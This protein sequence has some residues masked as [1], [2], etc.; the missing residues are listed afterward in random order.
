MKK[1]LQ[2]SLLTFV[3]GSIAYSLW[4]RI[5]EAREPGHTASPVWSTAKAKDPADATTVVVTYFTTDARCD[6]CLT[7]EKRARAIVDEQFAEEVKAGRVRFQTLNLDRPE[8]KHF[9]RDYNM[10][11]KTVVVSL[12]A[13]GEVLRWEKRDDVWKLLNAPEQFNS[14]VAA[15]IRDL[16]DTS[17]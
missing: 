6:S 11:F 9:A 7:I 3:F 5:G 17:S 15:S 14:Y 2:V 4:S 12:E 13:S 8:N 1:F 16:L 10:A